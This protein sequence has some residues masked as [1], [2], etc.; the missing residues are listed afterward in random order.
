MEDIYAGNVRQIDAAHVPRCSLFPRACLGQHLAVAD[1]EAWSQM[2]SVS[3]TLWSVI[4]RQ[5]RAL[6]ENRCVESQSRQS[7]RCRQRA[8]R[9][10]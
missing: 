10:R 6:S 9:A 7:G 4:R 1:D 8:R 2:P 3:R 5:C